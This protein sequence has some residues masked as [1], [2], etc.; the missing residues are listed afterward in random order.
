[1]SSDKLEQASA[2]HVHTGAH[3]PHRTQ[4]ELGLE[5]GLGLGPVHTE[6]GRLEPGLPGLPGYAPYVASVVRMP[7]AAA[8]GLHAGPCVAAHGGAS[9]PDAG[10]PRGV[11]GTDCRAVGAASLQAACTQDRAR[12]QVP[13]L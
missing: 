7:L 3:M 4:P 8:G 11:V 10:A 9:E 1:M 13:Y 12:V 6:L 2:R 5:L